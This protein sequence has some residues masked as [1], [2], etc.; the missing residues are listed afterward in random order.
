MFYE[1][2]QG[3]KLRDPFQFEIFDSVVFDF[4]EFMDKMVDYAKSSK[5]PIRFMGSSDGRIN[6][7]PIYK[8]LIG[9]AIV[10]IAMMYYSM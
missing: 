4:Y 7:F 8:I 9:I 3:R 1:K 6:F 2:E 5:V 10:G